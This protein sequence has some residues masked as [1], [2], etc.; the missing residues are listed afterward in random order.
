MAL[1][2][3]IKTAPAST[4]RLDHIPGHMGLPIFGNTFEFLKDPFAFHHRRRQEH[5]SVYKFGVF[6]GQ[7]VALYGADALEYV[8]MD[9][10]KIFGSRNGWRLLEKLFPNGL[11]L[12]DFEDHRS[13]RRIMQA[14]FK[15]K[16]MQ[17]YMLR[18]NEGI[19]HS[20]QAWSPATRF[21]FY[22][23]IKDLT[24]ELGASVFLGL[25]MGDEAAKLNQAFIDEV[26]ASVAVIR[27]P[28][29]GTAMGRGVKARAFLLAYFRDLIPERRAG[30]GDD[31]F[32]QFCKAKSE[33]GAF[34]S[35]D[36]IVDHLNFL[37]MA[38]HDTTTSALT[39]MVW[40]L[41][42]YPD[43]QNAVREEVLS[44][45]SEQLDYG[46]LDK[47]VLTERV[48]KEALRFRPPVPFLPRFAN[49]AFEFGGYEI[50]ADTSVSVSP[51]MVHMA[52]EIWTQPT[53]FDPDR[54]SDNRAEDRRHRFAW[55]PFGGGAHKC[56]GM[57][58]A[59]MQVRAFVHQFLQHYRVALPDGYQP[60]WLSIPIPKPRDGLPIIL[61]RL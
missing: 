20:M 11:M 1:S 6:G 27:R 16:P 9:R 8:L 34:F 53:L 43:W 47:L 32:S 7:T 42:A 51:G 22:P 12:R 3:T 4:G 15:P 56:I 37:L 26:A 21:E 54:F 48:F 36:E 23:A 5:G 19:A 13:H 17:D 39:T 38:A 59:I 41:A 24:L 18:L 35:D 52:E 44:L 45:G 58:F 33:D 31:M 40:A 10:D 61:S 25:E 29:P 49:E 14:A 55:T 46:D 57:H 2:E 28:W 30:D 60:R 50:P